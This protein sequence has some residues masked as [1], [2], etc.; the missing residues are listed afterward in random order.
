MS[1][2]ENKL[3]DGNGSDA[4]AC[5]ARSRL[6]G[7]GAILLAAAMG[8]IY[9]GSKLRASAHDTR[10]DPDRPKTP[11][12]LK[13]MEAARLRREKRALKKRKPNVKL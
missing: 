2:R 5:S 1:N 8:G 4:S 3:K 13:R 12:D 6:S 11:Q 7:S 10:H 9:G